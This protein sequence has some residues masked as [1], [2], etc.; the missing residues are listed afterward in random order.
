MGPHLNISA[1][2]S[3]HDAPSRFFRDLR[4]RNERRAELARARDT[5][6]RQRI[7]RVMQVARQHRARKSAGR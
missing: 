6:H 7:E 5:L 4:V 2:D 3:P 1:T